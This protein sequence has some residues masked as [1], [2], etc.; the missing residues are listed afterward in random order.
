LKTFSLST[1]S[2]CSSKLTD[3]SAFV[4]TTSHTTIYRETR[5]SLTLHVNCICYFRGVNVK[6]NA[7]RLVAAHAIQQRKDLNTLQFGTAPHKARH[8]SPTTCFS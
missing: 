4:V 3:V 8:K 7:P 1:E 5:T 6:V 2:D